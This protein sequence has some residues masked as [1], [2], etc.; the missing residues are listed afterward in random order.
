MTIARKICPLLD[1]PSTSLSVRMLAVW[2]Q[3]SIFSQLP[4]YARQNMAV[5]AFTICYPINSPAS[6][7]NPEIFK[8]RGPEAIIYK[9]LERGGPKYLK[10]AFECSFQSFSYKSFANIPPKRGVALGPSPKSA[11]ALGEGTSSCRTFAGIFKVC[12]A[13]PRCSGIWDKLRYTVKSHF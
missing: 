8:R 3:C 7:A 9:I 1:C 5:P 11:T 6:G 10:K 13:F 2:N 4:L 12:R